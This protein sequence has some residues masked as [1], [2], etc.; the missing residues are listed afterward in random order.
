MP[1]L[2]KII[3][4]HRVAKGFND[5]TVKERLEEIIKAFDTEGYG[6]APEIIALKEEA[7]I[8][9][10]YVEAGIKAMIFLIN[11]S[12]MTSQIKGVWRKSGDR[13]N[14]AAA[15]VEVALKYV[16]LE[17]ALLYNK[18]LDKYVLVAIL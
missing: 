15:L 7:K 11:P 2:K 1:E 4:I 10:S 16:G 12:E 5:L 17:T 8:I 14:G 9:E 13:L 6:A 3:L 18:E